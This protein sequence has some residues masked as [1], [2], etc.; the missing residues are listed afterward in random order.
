MLKD[1]VRTLTY[2]RAILNN[3]EFF[4]G[5][6][7]LDVGSGTGVLSMFAA[8]AGAAKVIGIENSAIVEQA[9]KIV[10]L[11]GFHDVI[12]FIRGKVE[13]VQLPVPKVDIIISEWMGY[14]LFYENML[15]T[16]LVARDRWLNPGGAVFPNVATLYAVGLED[17]EYRHEKIDYWD[18]VYGFNFAP[19]KE[20]AKQ[21][22]LV[23][24]VEKEAVVT[25]PCIL[26]RVDI[27]TVRPEELKQF[28]VPFSITAQREDTVHALVTYFDCEFTQCPHPIRFST[29][30]WCRY[31]HWKQTVFYLPSPQYMSRGESIQGY[32]RMA[33]NI[34]NPRDMDIDVQFKYAGRH[35]DV[36]Q[37]GRYRLR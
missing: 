6:I 26:K 9:Q 7:V 22:P 12:T 31:T 25:N 37:I 19:I 34:K 8:Q 24:T 27:T 5:K 10:D 13:E 33:S 2:Q 16:V 14:C 11:N 30:P 20:Q 15:A 36:D 35:G 21:E 4:Q 28:E 23:D 3:R 1:E 29:A 18:N 32:F 17:E